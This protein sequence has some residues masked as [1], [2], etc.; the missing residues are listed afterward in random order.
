MPLDRK[1]LVLIEL[2]EIN[3]KVLR[4]YLLQYPDRFPGFIKLLKCQNITT[5]SEANYDELEPWIQWPSV[6]LCKTF[7]QHKIYRLGDIVQSNDEQIFEQIERKGFKVGVISAMNAAN[8]L[9]NPAYFIPD[10]WTV[11]N[12]DPSFW[13]RLISSAINQ[14]VNDNSQSK[15]TL[16]TAAKI[17]MAFLKFAK[18]SHYYSYIR[19]VIL[20]ISS[21]WNRALILDLLLHDIHWALFEKKNP[22]FS[23]LFL[24]AG[25]HIQHHYLFNSKPL[26]SK[27]DIKNP[28]WYLPSSA[29]PLCD[30]LELYDLIINEYISRD[31]VEILVATAL[32]QKA[33]DSIK[34]YYRLNNHAEFLD[35][36][37]IQYAKV[38]PR[39]TRDFLVEFDS[40]NSA[41]I[42]QLKL[43]SMVVGENRD[44]LF[45]QI[46]NRGK[47]LFITLTYPREI[48]EFTKVYLEDVELL[49]NEYVS[50]VA[51][52]N[53]MHQS[54][55]YAFFSNGLNG[56]V[57]SESAH[58]SEIGF[59]IKKYFGLSN[60]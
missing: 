56:L 57:P 43:S 40:V 39:M 53:G 18:L 49:L 59:V 17:T 20:S 37:N 58:V 8:R 52:K 5:S 15:I 44:V 28:S 24:N 12:P 10:P 34:Y 50:F 55:G 14:A 46:D 2:N 26:L 25:A 27:V 13:S 3:F 47:S 38:L 35:A 48:T 4:C 31:D 33:Y 7:A 19:F 21:S 45:G 11:T 29:D 51:I 9:K 1:K 30:V 23:T 42:A 60:V 16:K 6:H 54:E 41:A 32:S 36:L 22:D